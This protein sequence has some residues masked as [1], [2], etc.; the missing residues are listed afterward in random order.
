MPGLN[1]FQMLQ[2]AKP[3]ITK[4][5]SETKKDIFSPQ[6]IARIILE[7]SMEWRLAK[8]TTEEDFARFLKE[9]NILKEIKIT[10][11]GQDK[12]VFR[13]VKGDVSNYQIALSLNRQSYISHYTAVFLHGLTNN[14][15]KR[16][17]TN[18][19]QS[20]K[21]NPPNKSNLTQEKIDSAFSK[22]M[23]KTKNIATF[24]DNSVCLING[25]NLNR[26]GVSE[27]PV[28]NATIP[29]TNIERT[30]IDI[31]VRP[32]YCGGVY[33]V[34]E[35]Y[36]MAKG[37]ISSNRLLATLKKIDFIYPYHQV[38]GFYLEK[39]GYKEEILRL[40]EKEDKLFNFYLAYDMKDKQFSKRWKLFYPKGL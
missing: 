16:V 2:H 24:F 30:L 25:K 6:D 13:Y 15:P 36:A 29:V 37:Q 5:F 11:S 40:F 33:E 34:Q 20:R 18:T 28:A 35:V 22:P 7:K 1:R 12:E 8:V 17:Y 27:I 26:L 21:S 31:A 9:R 19:E 10:F 39:A 32:D 38:I 3:E 23:R 4:F 14:I